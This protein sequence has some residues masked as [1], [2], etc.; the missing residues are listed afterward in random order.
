MNTSFDYLANPA[1]LPSNL[2]F[3]CTNSNALFKIIE[4]GCFRGGRI[5]NMNDLREAE[6]CEQFRFYNWT[7]LIRLKNNA[8]LSLSLKISNIQIVILFFMALKNLEC[9]RNML[10][11]IRVFV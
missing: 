10:I 6:L 8:I 4:S 11:I 5:I 9:G 1:R 2:L 7:Y 3:H